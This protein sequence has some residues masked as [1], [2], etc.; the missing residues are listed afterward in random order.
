MSNV[1][2]KQILVIVGYQ[3]GLP[4]LNGDTVRHRLLKFKTGPMWRVSLPTLF[5]IL[6]KDVIA[7]LENF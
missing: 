5:A 6:T 3:N 4:E 2:T 7:Q 1:V